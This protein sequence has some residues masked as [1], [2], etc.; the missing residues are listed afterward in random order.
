MHFFIYF[1]LNIF[2]IQVYSYVITL[3]SRQIPVEVLFAKK[4]LASL[5]IFPDQFKR[6][7]NEKLKKLYNS[8][9]IDTKELDKE[10][11]DTGSEK[12]SKRNRNLKE[13]KA[14]LDEI[15]KYS[16]T[17]PTN[18]EQKTSR[19]TEEIN[20]IVESLNQLLHSKDKI[21]ER[22]RIGYIDFFDFDNIAKNLIKD[23]END[24]KAKDIQSWVNF[25]RQKRE[26]RVVSV[27]TGKTYMWVYSP[28]KRYFS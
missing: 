15:S 13:V 2:V 10:D 1:L 6:I 19:S 17:A 16:T 27:D 20:Q 24:T 11:F 18:L 22:D 4:H 23:Y 7:K 5:G 3:K 14:E 12:R 8:I 9:D 25:H 21:E 26:L 28:N